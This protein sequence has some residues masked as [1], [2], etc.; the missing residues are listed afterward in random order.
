MAGLSCF[1]HLLPHHIPITHL[2][3]SLTKSLTLATVWE[4][5]VGYPLSPFSIPLLVCVSPLSPNSAV[6][7]KYVK[8]KLTSAPTALTP[9]L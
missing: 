1:Q 3:D 5:G 8:E 2:I 9:P 6:F 4:I 7:E